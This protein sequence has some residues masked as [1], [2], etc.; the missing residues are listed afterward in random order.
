MN[1]TV[2]LED[3][4]EAEREVERER[5]VAYL[6]YMADHYT[7]DT[8][9]RR[10]LHAAATDLESRQHWTPVATQRLV[11]AEIDDTS[12]AAIAEILRQAGCV[13]AKT[14]EPPAEGG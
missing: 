12:D 7:L 14:T 13:P 4:E 6:R 3:I 5:V 2:R 1:R 9:P 11:Q 8:D 10:A